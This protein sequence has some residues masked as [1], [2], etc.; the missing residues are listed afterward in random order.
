MGTTMEKQLS[1]KLEGN[2]GS[3]VKTCNCWETSSTIL[4]KTSNLKPI[5]GKLAG[6]QPNRATNTRFGSHYFKCREFRH[7]ITDYQKSV[8]IG[9]ALFVDNVFVGNER[10]T[11][12]QRM[13][14]MNS[15]KTLILMLSKKLTLK[16]IF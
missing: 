5:V 1:C 9:K 10:F 4:G 6:M 11:N 15:N 12:S 3:N 16:K 7:R 2:I 13:T 14:S 8:S